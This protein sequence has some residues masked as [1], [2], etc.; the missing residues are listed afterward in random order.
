[1]EPEEAELARETQELLAY[2]SQV[3]RSAYATVDD[4]CLVTGIREE[5]LP[6]LFRAGLVTGIPGKGRH[7]YLVC[8]KASLER[9]RA[10]RHKAMLPPS[11]LCPDL[12]EK[13]KKVGPSANGRLGKHFRISVGLGAAAYHRLADLV[14]PY[15]P[16]EWVKR[17]VKDLILAL[18]GEAAAIPPMPEWAIDIREACPPGKFPW[19][20]RMPGGSW[21]DDEDESKSWAPLLWKAA[22]GGTVSKEE[23]AALGSTRPAVLRHAAIFRRWLT[24]YSGPGFD[25]AAVLLESLDEAREEN[26]R[27]KEE[28]RASARIMDA[29]RRDMADLARTV[30]TTFGLCASRTESASSESGGT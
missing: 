14:E 11:F 20:E 5:D 23:A 10:A 4:F 6:W 1:M 19:G 26:Q 9:L 8:V 27:W 22:W 17:A 18:V 24:M 25:P 3:L 28:A 7:P 16:E 13:W 15:T 21:W 12:D 30:R 2:A 29:V